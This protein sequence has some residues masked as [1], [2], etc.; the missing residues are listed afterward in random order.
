MFARRR[1]GFGFLT[2]MGLGAALMYFFD[3]QGGR[4]R[5]ALLRDQYVHIARKLEDAQRIVVRDAAQRTRGLIAQAQ[6]AVKGEGHSAD[7]VVLVERVRS[8]IGRAVSHPHAIEVECSAG[9]VT[10][11]G[12]VLAAEVRQ[13][14]D[15]VGAVRGVAD[16][17]NQLSVYAEPGSIPALQGGV[18]REG[19]HSE[20]M[21]DHWSPSARTLAGGAGTTLAL[22]GLLRGGLGGLVVGALGAAL[23]A[24]ASANRDV[25]TLAGIGDD[26]HAPLMHG[27]LDDASLPPPGASRH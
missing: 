1:N 2:A 15:C 5:R 16:V 23:L 21:Q 26:N 6:R 17:D 24:R 25:R 7:D 18:P 12:P 13:L 3:P 19:A 9:A 27:T 22:F 20:W 4:R 10:L 14:I 8:A 11:K